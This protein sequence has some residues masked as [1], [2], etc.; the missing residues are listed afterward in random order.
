MSSHFG[1]WMSAVLWDRHGEREKEIT[2]DF[3]LWWLWWRNTRHRASFLMCGSQPPELTPVILFSVFLFMCVLAVPHNTQYLSSSPGIEPFLL[4]WKDR[5]STT[6][7]R[8][9]PLPWVSF[10]GARPL[11]WPAPRVDRPD[12]SSFW[13][14]LTRPSVTLR[15]RSAKAK[16]L[17]FPSVGSHPLGEGSRHAVWVHYEPVKR[18]TANT[19]HQHARPGTEPPWKW[20]HQRRSRLRTPAAMTSIFSVT[21]DGASQEAQW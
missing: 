12:L 18:L 1:S 6:R 5:C 2:S 19:H 13:I 3:P 14:L 8:E 4:Q 21:H 11:L 15:M 17:W 10:P 20:T 9:A 16:W 7:P